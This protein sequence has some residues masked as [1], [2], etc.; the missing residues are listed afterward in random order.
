MI[1][2]AS[3]LALTAITG[4]TAAAAAPASPNTIYCPPEDDRYF[5]QTASSWYASD[6]GTLVNNSAGT[7]TKTYTH[8]SNKSY[9]T[10]VAGDLGMSIDFVVASVNTKLNVST[11]REASYT[12]T[13][14]FTVTAPAHT[15]VSYRDGILKRTILI[16]W[17][18]TYSNCTV[19]TVRD[20]AYL[21]D[22]YSVA[23]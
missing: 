22:N 11:S 4:G 23:S 5:Q 16:T 3:A 20:Y 14:T 19:K 7:I 9:S 12:T 15:T 18:H 2:V 17:Y 21:A 8:T 1:A 10:T 13:T 6:S